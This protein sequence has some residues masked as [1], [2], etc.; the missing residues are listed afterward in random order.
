M[1]TAVLGQHDPA[2]IG[3]RSFHILE[4][5]G[6]YHGIEVISGPL[7]RARAKLDDRK[8]AGTGRIHRNLRLPA[9]DRQIIRDIDLE[10]LFPR[11]AR[12]D[13]PD[14]HERHG[15]RP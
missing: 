11:A 4:E 3:H 2:S 8:I 15:C 9:R 10:D 1:I 14:R 12:R 7:D 6:E 5:I 13:G